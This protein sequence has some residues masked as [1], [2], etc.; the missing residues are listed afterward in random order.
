MLTSVIQFK[1]DL[2]L[3]FGD[4]SGNTNQFNRYGTSTLQFV[5]NNKMRLLTIIRSQARLD[6]TFESSKEIA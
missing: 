4:N 3:Q 1:L 2:C 6:T 5:Y